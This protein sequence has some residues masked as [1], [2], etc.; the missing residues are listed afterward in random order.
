[1][2]IAS[3]AFGKHAP[4]S[5]RGKF[6]ARQYVVSYETGDGVSDI[7]SIL[8]D[9][10]ELGAGSVHILV[11]NDTGVDLSATLYA[12]ADGITGSATEID[13]PYKDETGTEVTAGG[14]T[15]NKGVNEVVTLTEATNI[16]AGTFTL[17][18]GG[19]TT[20]ALQ[21]N[22][23]AAE[24]Q[25][26]LEQ[27]S[28]IG[29]GNVSVTGGILTTTPFTITFK[30]ALKNTNVGAVT[31]DQ[32]LLTGTFN[33]AVATSGAAA[34][35]NHIILTYA[36]YPEAAAFRFFRLKLIPQDT[37]TALTAGDVTILATLK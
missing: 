34:G 24:L 18:F 9:T 35:F 19:Q 33:V 17:T 25:L 32:T 22:I 36:S 5:E 11:K 27:L 31:R 23:T 15:V 29:V 30:G 13:I 3:K 37:Y 20:P 10:I 7:A 6:A 8:F 2:I 1:M 16:T 14:A 21:H 26:A 12:S 4:L 28:S